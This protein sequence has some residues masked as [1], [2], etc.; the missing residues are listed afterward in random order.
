V[1]EQFAQA[2]G[3]ITRRYGGTGLGLAISSKIV[4]AMGGQLSV[5]SQPGVGST[6]YFAIELGACEAAVATAKPETEIAPATSPPLSLLLAEDN[7]V[8][9]LL[10][11]RLLEKLGHRVTTVSNG[12]EALDIL[13]A[14]HFDVVLMDLQMPEL[15]GFQATAAI[16]ERERSGKDHQLIVAMTAH[17]FK[18]DRERCLAAGMDGYVSKPINIASLNA[19]LAVVRPHRSEPDDALLR[20]HFQSA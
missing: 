6:F 9:Q 3:S 15:D 19:A 18:E 13:S 2:D 5:E 11:R 7:P 14:G 12:L 20:R 4:A 1:F 10:A 17:A 8:N 16:R